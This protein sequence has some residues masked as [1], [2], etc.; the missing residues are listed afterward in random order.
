MGD[1]TFK[2]QDDGFF[3]IA[4]TRSKADLQRLLDDKSRQVSDAS[5]VAEG[6]PS[7][8]PR[9]PEPPLLG[10]GPLPCCHHTV[11]VSLSC[12]LVRKIA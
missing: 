12:G 8:S 1:K 3:R 7:G 10:H 5:A 4:V 2:C 11:A 6:V 9:L